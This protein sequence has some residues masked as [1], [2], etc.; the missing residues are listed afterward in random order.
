MTGQPLRCRAPARPIDKA[1]DAAH[2]CA[3]KVV[4][5][6]GAEA[7]ITPNGA[8]RIDKR[9]RRWLVWTTE[10]GPEA[11][12]AGVSVGGRSLP[13]ASPRRFRAQRRG[14]RRK[15]LTVFT[16]S[17]S[18]WRGGPDHSVELPILTAR[19]LA[20]AVGGRQHGGRPPSRHPLR[21]PLSDR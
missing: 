12:A 15:G 18:R 8:D 3:P 16:T 1:L 5:P 20:P 2:A 11:L 10:T 4:A 19:K 6:A 21:S 17:T 7:A 9:Q 14:R 13:G